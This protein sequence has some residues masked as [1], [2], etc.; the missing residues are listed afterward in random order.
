MDRDIQIVSWLSLNPGVKVNG[1]QGAME[2]DSKGNGK[3]NVRT[4]FEVGITSHGHRGKAERRAEAWERGNHDLGNGKQ[5]HWMHGLQDH[6]VMDGIG[7]YA[8]TGWHRLCMPCIG[9]QNLGLKQWGL[10]K[11]LTELTE[12]SK[13]CFRMF[14]HRWIR[15]TKWKAEKHL[16]TGMP[17][18]ER[19]WWPEL[20]WLHW[21]ERGGN[22][23]LKHYRSR[24]DST[25]SMLRA[26][27]RQ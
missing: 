16:E 26:R 11:A 5:F 21:E 2:M 20:G 10:F 18:T 19:I 17:L 25:Y 15:K 1:F 9:V 4:G 6:A 24:V 13:F 12:W 3:G 22:G 14:S 23:C 7:N 8:G 27:K